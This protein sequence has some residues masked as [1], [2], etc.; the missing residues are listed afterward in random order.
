MKLTIKHL[1]KQYRRDFWG[2]REFDLEVGPGVI[3][4]LGPNGAGKSTLMRMLATITQPSEGTIKW[5]DVD[6][7]RSPDTLRAALGYLPQDFGIY[8]NLSGREFLEYIAAIK[9]LDGNAARRRIDELLVVVNLVDAAKRPLGSYSGGM[10][11]RVGIAQA[12]LN[13]PQLLIVDEPTA[14]LDPEERVR[15]RNLLSDLS[16]ERIIF[17][18]THIVSDVEAT[19]TEIVIIHKG[20]K[21]L[22]AAPEKILQSLDGQVWQW[23]V[24]SEALV[25]LKQKHIIS[26]TVRRQDGIQVRVV[27]ETAPSADAQPIAPSLEDVYLQLVSR[28]G[29][30]R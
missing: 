11:Q 27:S 29:V 14:G 5:N 22:H 28:N 20:R 24:P 8:P 26:G 16:G 23:V 6:I 9:G 3:G 12:L 7:V 17:L 19:A 21:L 4:L 1:S 25:A 15:F 13:D 10:K 30:T 18:S 2:L